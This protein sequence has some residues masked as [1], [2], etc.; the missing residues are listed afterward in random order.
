MSI[1]NEQLTIDNV[2]CAETLRT[3]R[4]LFLLRR[5]IFHVLFLF[6]R[7]IAHMFL[8]SIRNLCL[9]LCFVLDHFLHQNP[10]FGFI[11]NGFQNGCQD[12]CQFPCVGID[13]I[14]LF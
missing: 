12:F 9:D 5:R 14:E 4:F 8:F 6:E 1:D 13:G 7:V 10:G 2:Y 3:S 11:L